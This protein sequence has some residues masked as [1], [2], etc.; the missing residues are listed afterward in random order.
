MTFVSESERIIAK[1]LRSRTGQEISD[2][3]SWRI[4]TALSGLFREKG[5]S[6]VDQLVCMLDAPD[7]SVLS[8]QVVEALLN[9]ET[10]FFRDRAMFDQLAL[11]V[12]P[13]VAKDREPSRKISILCAGCSTGQ[14]ALS[15]AMIFQDQAALWRDWAIE[16]TGVD[17]SHT[18]IA[19][20]RA[21][22][23]SQFEIQR[24]L[25]VVQMLSHFSETPMG[26]EASDQLR[27]MTN[28][29]VHNLLNPLQSSGRFDVILCRNVLLYFDQATR[30]KV[31]SRLL[32]S[33]QPHGWVLLGAGEKIADPHCPLQPVGGGIN[34]YRTIPTG[35]EA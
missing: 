15:L 6:N 23:Y 9:N 3:R 19:A 25:S 11:R 12:L 13:R 8:Q 20:A 10:Y 7:Q 17:I 33:L 1:L 14:E 22:V 35:L 31:L 4:S 24:G 18:A 28:F 30:A 29:K 16:I 26:W 27:K 21:G 2:D 5:I 34:L 32:E